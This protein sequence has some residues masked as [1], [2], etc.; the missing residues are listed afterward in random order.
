MDFLRP[1]EAHDQREAVLIQESNSL[2]V[3]Q[4]RIRRDVKVPVHAALR[5]DVFDVGRDAGDQVPIHQRFPAEE[6]TAM[7]LGRE[8]IHGF[9]RR[10]HR[11]HPALFGIVVP[12][13]TVL[14]CEVAGVR[15]LKDQGHLFR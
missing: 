7:L 1:V 6:S 2:V 5:R 11:H 8:Q 13:E 15:G 4:D 12:N 9:A 3:E 14:A 10:V